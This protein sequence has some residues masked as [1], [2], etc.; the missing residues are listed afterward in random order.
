MSIQSNLSGILSR[1]GEGLHT[2]FTA[3]VLASDGATATVQ[4]LYSP[5]GAPAVPLEG[6]P[7]PRSVRKAETVTEATADGPTHWTKL[8]PPEAGDIVLCVCTEHVLGDSWRGGSVSR[9]G[10]I[11]HQMGDAVIAAIF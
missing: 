3:K 9:V 2:A 1:S 8:T 10:D 6:V 5:S 4:P 11:H 7:I